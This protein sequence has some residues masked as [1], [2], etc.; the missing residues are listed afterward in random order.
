MARLQKTWKALPS[1]VM[2]QWEALNAVVHP[3]EN[4]RVRNDG[5]LKGNKETKLGEIGEFIGKDGPTSLKA[6]ALV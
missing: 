3:A 1:K 4:F 5:E 6:L 2:A